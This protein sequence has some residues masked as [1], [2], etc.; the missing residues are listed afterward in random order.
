[1]KVRGLVFAAGVLILA[2][3]QGHKP[4]ADDLFNDVASVKGALPYPVMD[5]KPLTVTV[6]R[7]AMTTSTLFGNDMA[8][9]AARNGQAGYPA[10]AVLGLVTWK[11]RE[12]PHWFGARIPGAPA[13]V[14]FVEYGGGAPLYRRFVGSP[15]SEQTGDDVARLAQIA[16]MKPVQLP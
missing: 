8:I 5:W 10:G 11:Q 16:A 2:G 15:L 9:A 12:D 1:M 13:S 6:D 14:E 3:C 7:G 4:T